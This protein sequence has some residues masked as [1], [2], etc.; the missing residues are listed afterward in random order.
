MINFQTK[1]KN[2]GKSKGLHQAKTLACPSGSKT[3]IGY[4]SFSS[5]TRFEPKI[6]NNDK[7]ISTIK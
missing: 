7:N 4:T 3:R 5:T 1:C 2:C 6:K